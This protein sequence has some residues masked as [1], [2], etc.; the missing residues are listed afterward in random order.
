MERGAQGESQIDGLLLHGTCLWEVRED[1][2]R[3]LE[4]LYNLTA[5]RL[6]QGLFPCLPAVGQG[7]VPH[8]A[9]QGMMGQPFDLLGYPVPGKP[10]EGLDDSSMER[11]PS[12][13]EEAAV[14]NLICQSVLEGVLALWEE[15]RFVQE[16]GRLEVCQAAMECRLG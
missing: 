1:A 15:T 10:L 9:P 11:P 3:R 5:G 6:C 13:L 7:L 8:F 4:V 2:E 12:L 14:G 16:L